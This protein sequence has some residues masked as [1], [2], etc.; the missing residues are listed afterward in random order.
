MR[1]TRPGRHLNRLQLEGPRRRS[2]KSEG[3]S[4]R[5]RGE[6]RVATRWRLHDA[7]LRLA[8]YITLVSDPLRPIFYEFRFERELGKTGMS[9]F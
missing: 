5:N 6:R 4:N 9:K 1:P 3:E 7:S 8:P 2:E